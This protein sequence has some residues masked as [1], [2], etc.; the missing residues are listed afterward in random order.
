MWHPHGH[1]RCHPTPDASKNVKF[2][3]SRNP[4]KFDEITRFRQKN[5][6]VKSVLS[7]EI[8]KISGFEP[9]LPFDP[10]LEN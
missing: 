1:A 7:C 9:K 2:L 5:L 10:C 8:S 3:L 6:K 4:A